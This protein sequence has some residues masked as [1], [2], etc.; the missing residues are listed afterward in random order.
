MGEQVAIPSAHGRVYAWN[1]EVQES[2]F[3]PLQNHE[4]VW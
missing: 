2:I 4:P 1:Q 3:Y